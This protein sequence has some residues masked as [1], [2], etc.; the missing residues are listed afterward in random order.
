M[1]LTQLQTFLAIVETGSFSSAGD[2]LHSVQS[3][4]TG[5]IRRL[6]EELGGP[7]FERGRGGARMTVLG[8][9]LEPYAKD[10][11]ARVAT[12]ET[13]L[14]DAAGG[15]APLRLGALETTAGS[16]LPALLKRLS[17]KLPEAIVTLDTGPS[18]LLTRKIWDRQ[19]DAAFVVGK[20]DESRFEHCAAF[21]ESLVV[22]KSADLESADTLLAFAD[23]CSYR[24]AALNWL[25]ETG[26]GD[27]SIREM[28][29]L[30]AILGCVGAGLGFAVAPRSAVDTYNALETLALKSLDGELATSHTSLIWRVDV[31]PSRA[32]NAL[33]DILGS[34]KHP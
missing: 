13:D 25:R 20:V 3:N 11:L 34:E 4:I 17:L 28:G 14:K 12:A 1:N 19:L 8:E 31:R 2:K 6:E 10:I 32:V 23:G 7:V 16:R 9:R 27:T 18:G 24:A 29:S 22:A 21:E 33:V 15:A 30:N 26:R 5:R